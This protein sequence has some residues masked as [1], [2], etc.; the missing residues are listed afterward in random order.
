MCNSKG[1]GSAEDGHL[2]LQPG[3]ILPRFL[4]FDHSNMNGEG[5]RTDTIHLCNLP[6]FFHLHISNLVSL[7]S[8]DEEGRM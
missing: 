2:E 7:L 5:Q 4:G 3:P 1:M 6:Y 8:V